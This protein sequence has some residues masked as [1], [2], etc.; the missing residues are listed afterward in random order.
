MTRVMQLERIRH[1]ALICADYERS[2]RF[3][4]R[5]WACA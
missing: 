2:R 3:Y 5:C 4:T 1:V